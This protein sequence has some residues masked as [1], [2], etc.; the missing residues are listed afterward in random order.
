MNRDKFTLDGV[1]WYHSNICTTVE[2]WYIMQK[3]K[4]LVSVYRHEDVS[5]SL[6]GAHWEFVYEGEGR[7]LV[8]EQIPAHVTTLEERLAYARA[9]ARLEG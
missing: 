9:L 4:V 2:R 6:T 1:E 8:A 5:S 7:K 3:R